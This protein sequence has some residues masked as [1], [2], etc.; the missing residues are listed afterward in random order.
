MHSSKTNKNCFSKLDFFGTSFTFM[1]DGSEKYYTKTGAFLTTLFFFF[2]VTM[3]FGFGMDLFQRKNPRVSLNREIGEYI[4]YNISNKDFIYAYRIEDSKG[5]LYDDKSIAYTEVFYGFSVLVNGSWILKNYTKLLTKKCSDIEDIKDQQSYFNIS[6]QN[7]YCIDF[8]NL[9]LGGFWDGNFVKGLQI[10][11]H[12]CK[13][14]TEIKCSSQEKINETFSNINNL[15]YSDLSM[16]VQPQMN[17]FENPI[18]TNLQNFYH[19]LNLNLNKKKIHTFKLTTMN[20][21]IGWLQSNPQISSVFSSDSITNDFNIKDPIE[22]DIVHYTQIYFGNK[23]DT[24]YRSYT[25]I[26]EILAV[27]GGFAKFLHTILAIVYYYIG[28]LYKTLF[29]IKN[30]SFKYEE[31]EK[32]NIV[33]KISHK[34][35]PVLKSLWMLK[36]KKCEKVEK[37]ELAKISLFEYYRTKFCK[38]RLKTYKNFKLYEKNFSHTMSI[39]NYFEFYNR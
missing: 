21:D 3:F 27:I 5:L 17:N 36:T 39:V 30:I 11:V 4:S 9:T 35:I 32:V 19:V 2:T 33:D 25:K 22:Q 26:Q 8:N 1:I 24:Y 7:W 20:N 15:F 38:A 6:L 12:Q 10:R 14:T 37:D 29:L 23:I 16:F 31:T 28:N 34:G 13:N 18:K